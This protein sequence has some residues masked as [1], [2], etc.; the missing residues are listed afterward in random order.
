MRP[1]SALPLLYSKLADWWPLVSAPADYA[2]EAAVYERLL[3]DTG[4]DPAVTLLEL[5]SGGGNNASYLRKRF[6]MTLSDL[7]PGMLE[8]SRSLNPDCEHLHGDMR[9]LRLNRQFDRVFVH[10]AIA[11]MTSESD[12]R[13]AIATAAAHCRRGGGVLLAPDHLREN[14]RPSTDHGG[15]DGSN[16]RAMRFLAWTW[17]P[18]PDDHTCIADYVYMLR[19]QNGTVTVEHERHIEGVFSR[20]LWLDLMTEVG[21]DPRAVPVEHSELEPGTY[22]VFVGRKL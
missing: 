22:E 1:G 10:D 5:G 15:H 12:L 4:D 6:R 7:S 18:E 3:L 8:V 14:F 16:G 20:Q 9:T 17:D 11:Y 19:E 21:F 2:E 13:L